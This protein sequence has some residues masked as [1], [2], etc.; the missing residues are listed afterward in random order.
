MSNKTFD[1]VIF[2][3]D[4]TLLDSMTCL[5]DW[6]H[7]AVKDYCLPSVTPATITSAFGPTEEQIITQFV[8]KDLVQQCLNAYYDL[9]AREHDR[10]FVYPG[11]DK[12]LEAVRNQGIPMALCT[13]KSRR[14]VEISLVRLGWRPHFQTVITGDDTTRFKPDPEGLNLILG[15]ILAARK[16]TIYIG[17]TAADTAAAVN[18]GVISGRAE[19]GTSGDMLPINAHPDYRFATPHEAIDLLAAQP[20]K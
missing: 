3:M 20:H 5:A 10:V 6:L 1:L 14:A 9:Y 19:W 4:G 16:R 11:I 2:D 8:S 17:D 13:G 12:L 15:Q 18:A 7:R